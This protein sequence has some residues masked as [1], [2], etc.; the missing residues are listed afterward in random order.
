MAFSRDI[1]SRSICIVLSLVI[2][3]S[4]PEKVHSELSLL[5]P[6]KGMCYVT[7]D[8]D[9]FASKYSD[10]SLAKLASMG[11]EYVS[12]CITHYQEKYDSTKIIE[13]E[14]TPSKKSI[15]H[16]IGKS[17]ELGMNI[18]MKPHIDLID[19]GD[20]TYWRA[21]IGS[22]T[23]KGWTKWFEEYRKFILAYAVMAEKMDVEVFCVGTELSFASQRTDEWKSIISEIRKVYS[24]KLVYA[25]NWDNF[26]NIDFWQD[27]DYV[28]I[29]AYFPLTYSTNPSL[30]DLKNGWRK[31]KNEIG[32]WRSAVDKPVLFTEI[33]Y[34]CTPEAPYSPW[35]V[36]SSGNADTNIQALCYK[37]F[38]EV[39]WN[40]P[41]FA[42]VYW[43]KWDTNVRS[44]G[45]YNRQFTPQNKPAQKIIEAHYKGGGHDNVYARAR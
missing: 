41:W 13:T 24:G 25:A 2:L 34:A 19:K 7:W 12:V 5:P 32:A 30:E 15:K 37:A 38:F 10:E 9:Q 40:E 44:G 1:F 28:G 22:A 8:K 31:W 23:E 14:R 20:G 33:G 42:G 43:W 29:D 45:R 4:L 3:F 17:H 27:L 18:M 39:I 11:V 6:Q 21:D 26:K 35:K 16:V 36:A